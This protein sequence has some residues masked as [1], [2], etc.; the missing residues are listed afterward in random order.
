MGIRRGE[1]S[2]APTPH[3][4]CDLALRLRVAIV[5]ARRAVPLQ[6]ADGAAVVFV[7]D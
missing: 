5:G 7:E 6:E 4:G 2:F 1:K 3:H